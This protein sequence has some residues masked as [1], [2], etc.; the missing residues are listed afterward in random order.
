MAPLP[1]RDGHCFP[2]FL[3]S[4]S[5]VI[6]WR[7]RVKRRHRSHKPVVWAGEFT[8]LAGSA[9]CSEKL[10]CRSQIKNPT[11]MGW[12]SP[13]P[14]FP[15]LNLSLWLRRLFS[16][17][18]AS[19]GAQ[20]LPLHQMASQEAADWQEVTGSILCLTK[21][22]LRA[23]ALNKRPQSLK[24]LYHLNL[25]CLISVVQAPSKYW[26]PCVTSEGVWD[27]SNF[28]ILVGHWRHHFHKHGSYSLWQG[29]S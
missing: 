19:S 8:L 9:S 12:D 5:L 15:V 28:H 7:I 24:G 21:P 27:G 11:T 23:V 3:S 6:K 16:L 13:F 14:L 2:L 1:P 20:V 10:G 18:S 4:V 17:V 29:R 22:V 25:Y 26:E